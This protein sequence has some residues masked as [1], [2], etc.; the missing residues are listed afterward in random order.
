MKCKWCRK[1]RKYNV[2][3]MNKTS[4]WD[5]LVCS[6]L[7][8]WWSSATGVSWALEFYVLTPLRNVPCV[9]LV[10]LAWIHPTKPEASEFGASMPLGPFRSEEKGGHLQ[11]ASWIALWK[12]C[13]PVALK[14][15]NLLSSG[16][17]IWLRCPKPR[18]SLCSRSTTSLLLF[19]IWVLCTGILWSNTVKE[20]WRV[21]L[22]IPAKF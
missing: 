15:P 6:I 16:L 19:F 2:H 22:V 5:G 21:F 3:I 11:T 17:D 4:N 12:R 18:W 1:T 10:F 14:E 8:P 13:C 9:P 7:N 20:R